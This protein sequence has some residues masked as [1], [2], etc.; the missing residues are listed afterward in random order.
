MYLKFRRTIPSHKL[1]GED[2][3][4]VWLNGTGAEDISVGFGDDNGSVFPCMHHVAARCKGSEA[5]ELDCRFWTIMDL[6]AE[7]GGTNMSGMDGCSVGAGDRDGNV[8]LD[9]LQKIG[10]EE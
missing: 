8:K 5:D 3:S 1:A 9:G 2:P 6:D 7:A 4:V 10:K